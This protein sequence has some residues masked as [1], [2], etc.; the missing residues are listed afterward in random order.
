M[1]S[2]AVRAPKAIH[3]QFGA[4][5]GHIAIVLDA[6][7]SMGP[8]KDQPEGEPTKF[9]EATQALQQVLGTL[10]RGATVSVWMFGEATG[11]EKTQLDAEKTIRNVFPAQR[12]D[13]DS[14]QM[15]TLMNAL[16]KVEPWNETPLLRTMLRAAQTD[17]DCPGGL[18]SMIVITDGIDNRIANDAEYNPEKKDIPTLLEENFRSIQIDF[19]GFK[20]SD[21]EEAKAREQ[22]QVIEQLPIPGHFYS[23]KDSAKLIA[24]L[25]NALPQKLR[26][27]VDRADNRPLFGKQNSGLDVSVDGEN[28]Q[29]IPGGLP[30]GNYQVRVYTDQRLTARFALSQSDLLLM[31]LNRQTLTGGP[32]GPLQFRR[33]VYS[34][35]DYPWKPWKSE[36]NRQDWIMAALQNQLMPDQSAQMLLTLEKSPDP[37]ATIIQQRRP[38]MLWMEVDAKDGNAD[39]YSQKWYYQPGYPAPTWTVSIPK[40]PGRTLPG[41]GE[42]TSGVPARPIAKIWWNPDQSPDFVSVL[43]DHDYALP[44]DVKNLSV[45]IGDEQVILESLKIETHEVETAAPGVNAPA[46]R[47]KL[48]CLVV[49]MSYGLNAPVWTRLRGLATGGSEHHYFSRANKYTG[50]FWPV[51]AEQAQKVLEGIEICSLARFKEDAAQRNYYIA[52]DNLPPPQQGDSRPMPPVDLS[53]LVF[54]DLGSNSGDWQNVNSKKDDEQLI[55]IPPLP[56][57]TLPMPRPSANSA[58]WNWRQEITPAPPTMPGVPKLKD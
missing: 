11:R 28:D 50:I 18:K 17:L 1:S 51:T 29:W 39:S 9:Q 54:R 34:R 26:Y 40:W 35:S 22:F 53:S 25:R 38:K 43:R 21:A 16:A 41:G 8:R 23:V 42:S 46:V 49:R 4:S 10:S 24:A 44:E 27:W 6:S 57:E 45:R 58:Q 30:P 3:D 48:P 56:D 12:W 47:K 19:I 2:I 37:L 32:P 5:S 7:G 36:S 52:M 31:E 55:T 13:P 20:I 14:N 33:I 15:D